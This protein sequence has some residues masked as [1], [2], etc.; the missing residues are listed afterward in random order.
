MIV[1]GWK[2]ESFVE[3]QFNSVG[4]VY[5]YNHFKIPPFP[6]SPSVTL[7]LVEEALIHINMP[8]SCPEIHRSRAGVRK[9]SSD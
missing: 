7:S 6:D 3:D 4:L 5:M 1:V 2:R 9:A 8:G